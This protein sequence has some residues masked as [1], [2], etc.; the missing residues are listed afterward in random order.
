MVRGPSGGNLA[1][2]SY[3]RT[4]TY[5]WAKRTHPKK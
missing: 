3:V 2:D 1:L 4:L 5:E